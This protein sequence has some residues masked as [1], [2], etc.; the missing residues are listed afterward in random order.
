MHLLPKLFIGERHFGLSCLYAQ[1][2][3]FEI[4]T[5]NEGTPTVDKLKLFTTH[6]FPSTC[7]QNH[8]LKITIIRHC[9]HCKY[10]LVF[11]TLLYKL[12]LRICESSIC[13]MVFLWSSIMLCW[14]ICKSFT[15]SFRCF[16]RVPTLVWVFQVVMWSLTSLPT[17]LLL[18][19]TLDDL[20]P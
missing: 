12:F 2:F 15:T 1:T 18:W 8:F 14:S 20:F 7:S 13:S 5:I 6:I 10:N 4:I 9:H 3:I 16:L 11:S 17:C 19:I